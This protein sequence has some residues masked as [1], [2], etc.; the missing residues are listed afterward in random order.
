MNG[1][2][3]ISTHLQSRPLSCAEIRQHALSVR[4][5]QKLAK[6]HQLEVPIPKDPDYLC[7]AIER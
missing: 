3:Y 6:I 1:S 5:A 4:I 7:E 2:H